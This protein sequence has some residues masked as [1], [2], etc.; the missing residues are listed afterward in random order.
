MYF[1]RYSGTRSAGGPPWST[2]GLAEHDDDVAALPVPVQAERDVRVARDVS[3]LRGIRPAVDQEARVAV[4]EEP[5]R[6]RHRR[7]VAA[8][9]RQPAE[10]LLA[11]SAGGAGAEFGAFVDERHARHSTAAINRNQSIYPGGTP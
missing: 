7:P 8:D 2:A 4:P 5:N 10:L 3:K 6:D 11:Q 1:S 9:R